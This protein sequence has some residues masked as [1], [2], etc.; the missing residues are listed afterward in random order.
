AYDPPTFTPREYYR[1]DDAGATWHRIPSPTPDMPPPAIRFL[2]PDI[3][4]ADGRISRD[5][6]KTWERWGSP[7]VAPFATT[8]ADNLNRFY[9]LDTGHFY[10]VG[11][12]SFFGVSSD[13]GRSW[14]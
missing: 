6:W 8:E 7:M 12:H 9:A 10:A 3:P 13:Q 14:N 1:S 11:E 5:G 4:V 2:D